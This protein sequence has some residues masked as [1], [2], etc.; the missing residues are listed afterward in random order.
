MCGLWNLYDSSVMCAIP[1]NRDTE[2]EVRFPSVRVYLHLERMQPRGLGVGAGPRCGQIQDEISYL[3]SCCAS[4]TV[5]AEIPEK[6]STEP[7]SA[8]AGNLHL[9]SDLEKYAGFYLG[10]RWF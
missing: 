4:V 5:R 10:G 2:D 6:D 3:L 1:F 9:R 8:P 7:T